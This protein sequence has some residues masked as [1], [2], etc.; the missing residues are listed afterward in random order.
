MER[1]VE[2]EKFSAEE[3]TETSLRPEGWEGYIGQEQI[4]KN[5]GVFIEASKKRGEALDHTLFFGPPGLGKTTLALIIAN[6][7]GSNIKVT[8][9]PMIEKSGDL[10]AI[11]TNLEEGDILFIDEIHRLSPAV[12]EILY[13]SMEDFRLDIIIGS[14]P[15][16]QTVKI[17][18]PRFTLIGATT[19]AGMLSNPLRD[20]FGMNF[21]M[22]FYTPEELA[23]IVMQAAQKLGKPIEHNAAL[24]I[25]RRSRGT[26]RIALRLLRRVRDF[27]DVADETQIHHERTAYALNELG[28]NAHGFDEMDIRLLELLVQAK[29]KAMGLSTIAAALSEDEGTIED[30]LEPYLLANGYLERTARGRV[31]TPKCYDVLRLTPPS[32]Q[33]GLF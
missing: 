10:A 11:L 6:E 4:K 26:P 25:A 13:P 2:I 7:M 23:R 30:V 5:L 22:N 32:G 1:I 27:A 21:R 18:L 24:E 14:G 29:G 12:E 33:T 16:A 3:T 19:R 31:A 15:A 20:R 17:D 28:I 9:A 8:A